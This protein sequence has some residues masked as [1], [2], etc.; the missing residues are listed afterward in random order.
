MIW[1]MSDFLTDELCTNT[2]VPQIINN[3]I[4]IVQNVADDVSSLNRNT[5]IDNNNL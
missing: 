5:K 2:E 1:L 3:F 4:L